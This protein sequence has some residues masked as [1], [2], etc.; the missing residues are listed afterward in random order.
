MS[1]VAALEPGTA[2]R[3]FLGIRPLFHPYP[4]EPPGL[5]CAAAHGLITGVHV[6]VSS[7]VNLGLVLGWPGLINGA[8]GVQRMSQPSR[9]LEIEERCEGGWV[10]QAS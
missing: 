4:T 9:G 10:S 6:R 1:R 8:Q 5:P 2:F 3:A 7:R